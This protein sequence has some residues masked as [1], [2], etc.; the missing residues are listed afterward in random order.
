[1]KKPTFIFAI[2]LL[3]ISNSGG[4]CPE[5]DLS[6]D[7]T[8]GLED[9]VIFADQWLAPAGCV[10]YEDQCADFVGNDGVNQEDLAELSL[11][12]LVT[13]TPEGSLQV[14]IEPAAARTAGAQWRMDSGTWHDSGDTQTEIL[15]GL[16][17][18]S[19]S[20]ISG[21]D[22][23][24]SEAVQIN[25]EGTTTTTGTYTE[26]VPVPNIVINE[27]HY[28]P[29]NNTE[30]VEFIELYNA[31]TVSINLNGWYFEGAVGYTFE[32]PLIM[33][34]GDYVVVCQNAT[35]VFDKF[36]VTSYG[37]FEGKLSSDGERLVL[38]D[39]NGN[40]V[41]EVDY[42]SEFPWP[43]AANGE[44]ASME[45]INPSLD[46]DLAGSWRSSGYNT[47]TRPEL[48]FGAPTP[49]AINSVYA[50]NVPPQIRQVEHQP[51][52]PSA[53]E[54]IVITAKVTDP[55]N[56]KRVYLYYQAVTPGNYIPAYLPI[57]ISSLISNPFQDQ[58]FNPDFENT[59]NWTTLMM[60]DDGTGDDLVSG[61]GIYTISVTGQLNRTLLRYRIKA[62]D[63][64]ESSNS[65]RVPYY[66]DPSLNF[67]CFVYNGVP[68]YV[69]DGDT[70]VHP[71]AEVESDYTYG[72]DTLT[73]LP[74]YTLITRYNDLYQCNGYNSS[75]QIEQGT[76]N[77]NYQYAGRAYNW[78]GAFVYDGKVY[79]HIGYRLRGGNG[80]Y[81][82]GA[83]GKRSMKFRFNRGNYFQ[84]R[85]IYGKKFPS[86]WQNL[87]TGKMMGNKIVWDG[88]RHYPY[89][90]NE[91]IDMK[92]FDIAD[93]P[94]PH[95]YWMH[96]RVVDGD[97]ETPATVAGGQYNGDFWGL[98]VAF[99]N[100]DGAFLE[101][102]GLPKGNL[103]KLSDKIY[104]GYDQLRY[105]GENAILVTND[106]NADDYENIRWNLRRGRRQFLPIE[107]FGGFLFVTI[108]IAMNGIAIR[109]SS[110]PYGVLIFS[111]D[112]HC[113]N[114][115]KNVAWYFT[116]PPTQQPT[117]IMGR[118]SSCRLMWTI[119][120]AP[121]L[122]TA[123]I[124]ERVRSLI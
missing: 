71:D 104:G 76:T 29:D 98:Y 61:D 64:S 3:F 100:Y 75:D 83:A 52:Q 9:L 81:N 93:V 2:I 39:A 88:W 59:A 35:A 14:T 26:T 1:M 37:P 63:D 51:G 92:L 102:L 17:T 11:N 32:S 30:Q 31:G 124:T 90:I 41:D 47:N 21:W 49:G 67:A 80:R 79:D 53:G 72:S 55:D 34:S 120:G 66:D 111:V 40:K 117:I 8:V 50:V 118:C 56:V 77:M 48:S 112:R 27:I 95:T 123:S 94:S 97:T 99:E 101:R 36:G 24:A 58:P 43:I 15:A 25:E 18:V 108:W 96:F 87:N 115:L 68:D 91:V 5:Q 44:G 109:P 69:V 119:A 65:I 86:K 16:H 23:P 103:Y 89:G 121:I 42:D 46:N 45:L 114:C 62:W 54:P 106:S 73:T 13:G 74:V 10:G 122:I 6:G 116:P 70:S 110:N 85:D 12:W 78:E 113:G 82:N 7:C 57:A 20:T 38:R 19:Y 22:T 60:K 107:P 33:D 105:Q 4:T 28:H 84:A